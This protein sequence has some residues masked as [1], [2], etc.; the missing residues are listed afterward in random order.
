MGY[1]LQSKHDYF[2]ATNGNWDYLTETALAFGWQPAG[3]VY[4]IHNEDGGKS[5][6]A[7]ETW[8]GGYFTNDFQRVTDN[9]AREL[10]A[11]LRRAIAAAEGTE[12]RHL[13]A[14]AENAMKN[15]NVSFVRKFAEFCEGGGFR[16]G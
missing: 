5:Y 15:L 10:A 1:D 4:P 9:D 16:I 11:A 7:G 3:T 6:E 13:S 12:A 2:S 14:R 8:S